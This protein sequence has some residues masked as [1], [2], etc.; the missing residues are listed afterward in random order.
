MRPP[1]P[2][3]ILGGSG[4]GKS[5]LAHH[6]NQL[7]CA[8]ETLEYHAYVIEIARKWGEGPD[9]VDGATSQGWVGDESLVG[10]SRA[11]SMVTGV[12]YDLQQIVT[13]YATIDPQIQKKIVAYWNTRLHP[14]ALTV[15]NRGG[16]RPL[17]EFIGGLMQ[18]GVS[19]SFWDDLIEP[20][21]QAAVARH[22]H[23]SVCIRYPS[24]A[25]L[26]RSLGGQI[27]RIVRPREE[28]DDSDRPTERFVDEIKADL[29]VINNGNRPQ[30][31]AAANM[32]WGLLGAEPSEQGRVTQ[33]EAA[34][35]AWR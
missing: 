33:I 14:S 19:S 6:F 7:A 20:D 16:H 35:L 5:T 29:T 28:E 21:I 3:G 12:E 23:V 10:L 22:G 15:R 18:E 26:I 34:A 13:A 17:L 4:S 31:A 25:E 2:I 24:N 32:A 9:W 8:G 27:V 30:L 11:V 1:R